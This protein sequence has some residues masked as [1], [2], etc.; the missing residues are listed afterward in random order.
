MTPTNLRQMRS[1]LLR[2]GAILPAASAELLHPPASQIP[3]LDG[4]RTIAILLVISGHFSHDFAQV[5]GPTF[6]S[7]LP[8][9]MN[10]WIGVDL[11][12]VLSGFFIGGQL[13]KELRGDGHINVGRFLLRRGLRIWPLYL[14]TFVVVFLL[15]ML[16]GDGLVGKQYGWS[17]LIFVTNFHNRGIVEGSWS[18]CIE[19]QFYIAAPLALLLLSTRFRHVRDFRPWLWGV[20][21]L[22]PLLRLAMWI[23]GTGNFFQASPSLFSILYYDSFTHCDG[24]IIGLLIANLWVTRDTVNSTRIRSLLLL[25][26]GLTAMLGLHLLQKEVFDFTGLALFFGSLVWFGLARP[27]TIFNNRIFYWLSRLSYGMYLNHEYMAPWVVRTFSGLSFLNPHPLLAN[28]FGVA[29]LTLISAA[30]ALATFCCVEYPFLQLRAAL[31]RSRT[32]NKP[33]VTTQFA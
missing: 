24:L 25:G 1:W 21:C 15:L 18:L 19:E 5:N 17:D 9:V 14:F 10:G 29:F 12:F 2:R 27:T 8:F 32:E 28:V 7:R 16:T 13:W 23:H 31:L 11:F 4:L 20:L 33:L 30:L 6:Y 22:P 26:A 3:F